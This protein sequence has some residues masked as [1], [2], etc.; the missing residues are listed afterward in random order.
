MIGAVVVEERD[1]R[2]QQEKLAGMR[3]GTEPEQGPTSSRPFALRGYQLRPL[4]EF[5][6][7]A[8]VL[9]R[10]SYPLTPEHELSPLDLALAWGRMAERRVYETLDV[11]Q[12]GRWYHYSWQRD[13]PL[14]EAEMRKSSANMHMIPA[15]DAVRRVLERA[16]PGSMLRLK[17][18]LV[19]VTNAKGLRWRSSL[20]REDSGAGA[21]ELV[22]VQ[23]ARIE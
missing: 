17:G 3:F 14:P 13:P 12:S 19:E 1:L 2:T 20:S 11:S 4:A 6:I 7:R 5:A 16:R 10:M 9:S 18:L 23:A 15:D 21:C 22:Y 8:R